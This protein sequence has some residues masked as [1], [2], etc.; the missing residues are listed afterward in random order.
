MSKKSLKKLISI[1][2]KINRQVITDAL[3]KSAIHR[4]FRALLGG[5]SYNGD[6]FIHKQKNQK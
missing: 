5:Y 3:I 1:N 4:K 2:Q 6:C